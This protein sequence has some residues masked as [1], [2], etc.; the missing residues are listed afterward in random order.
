MHGMQAQL[1]ER[2]CQ[3]PGQQ[4]IGAPG[5]A[6]AKPEA[7]GWLH[8]PPVRGRAKSTHAPVCCARPAT[9]PICSVGSRRCSQSLAILDRASPACQ[10]RRKQVT[11]PPLLSS[12]SVAAH[13]G[14]VREPASID[15]EDDD[16]IRSP[17]PVPR[18]LV[19]RNPEL[20]L[21]T[22]TMERRPCCGPSGASGLGRWLGLVAVPGCQG[23]CLAL[24]CCWAA[25]SWG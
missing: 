21:W 23:T 13:S 19:E 12:A 8:S 15:I 24:C 14:C 10:A 25:C 22:L 18:L 17:T 20:S 5:C 3:P 7:I 6:C 1:V 16:R 4:A 11:A 2:A 9:D